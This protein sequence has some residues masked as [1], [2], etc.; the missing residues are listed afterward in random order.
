MANH[1]F[2]LSVYINFR[3][4]RRCIQIWTNPETLAT[5]CTQDTGRRQT[6]HINTTQ[7]TKMMSNTNPQ[8]T[9]DEPKSLVGKNMI[10]DNPWFL[11]STIYDA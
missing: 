8:K 4:N 1:F 9:G 10:F 2:S 11:D 7:K 3:E 5:L 6:K